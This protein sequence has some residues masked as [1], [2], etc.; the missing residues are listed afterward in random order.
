MKNCELAAEMGSWRDQWCDGF[1]GSRIPT[2]D[3][4]RDCGIESH[5]ES[6]SKRRKLHYTL[7][8]A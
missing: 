4:T 5:D 6:G 7:T 1:K 2:H 3:E 8:H